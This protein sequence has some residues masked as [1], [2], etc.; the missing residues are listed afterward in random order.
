MP[1]LARAP[2]GLAV[3]VDDASVN[4]LDWLW[5]PSCDGGATGLNGD[6][7]RLKGSS[8]RRAAGWGCMQAEFSYCLLLNRQR[9]VQSGCRYMI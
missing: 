2:R 6:T 8:V 4:A 9:K 7:S 3:P 1:A 5:R